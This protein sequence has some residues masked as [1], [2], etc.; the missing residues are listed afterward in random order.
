MKIICILLFAWIGLAVPL[1][2]RAQQFQYRIQ[3]QEVTFLDGESTQNLFPIKKDDGSG[4]YV[5]SGQPHWSQNQSVFAKIPIAYQS[6]T[7]PRVIAK[8]KLECPQPIGN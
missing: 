7:K 2:V 1:Q 4:L 6:G 8:F 5:N 3:L